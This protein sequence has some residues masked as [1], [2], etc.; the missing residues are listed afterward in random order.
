MKASVFQ[1]NGVAACEDGRITAS[2]L[3][4]STARSGR[5]RPRRAEGIRA[6]PGLSLMP[7]DQ[8]V[9]R[10][11]RPSCDVET[12]GGRAVM[13]DAGCRRSRC[14]PPASLK[15]PTGFALKHNGLLYV[16]PGFA[17]KLDHCAG[18]CA[19]VTLEFMSA[20]APCA[21]RPCTSPNHQRPSFSPRSFLFFPKLLNSK[22][23]GRSELC[24]GQS[25]QAESVRQGLAGKPLICPNRLATAPMPRQGRLARLLGGACFQRR[26][27]HA[28]PGRRRLCPPRYFCLR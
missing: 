26:K 2:R 7:V 23:A 1:P 16:T 6:P 3:P 20:S 9:L 17:R 11:S 14:R 15:P 13:R 27:K 28:S 19:H 8:A 22:N 18:A 10:N 21:T 12:H 24:L 25:R 5:L 4:R